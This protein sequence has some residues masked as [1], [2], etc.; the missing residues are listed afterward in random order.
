[1]KRFPPL[2]TSAPKVPEQQVMVLLAGLVVESVELPPVVPILTGSTCDLD[3]SFGN[4]VGGG[5]GGGG[6]GVCVV[7]PPPPQEIMNVRKIPAKTAL[8]MFFM[9]RTYFPRASRPRC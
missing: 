8:N 2:L 6:G 3:V 5:G 1:M 7:D 4:T 9:A